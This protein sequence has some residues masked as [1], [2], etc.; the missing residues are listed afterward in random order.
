[1]L[2]KNKRQSELNDLFGY[3]EVKKVKVVEEQP[4]L[5]KEKAASMQQELAEKWGLD[6]EKISSY[7]KPGPVPKPI[8]WER[9]LRSYIEN[10][11]Q[12]QTKEPLQKPSLQHPRDWKPKLQTVQVYLQGSSTT[13]NDTSASTAEAGEEVKEEGGG[14]V[15]GGGAGGGDKEP[16]ETEAE[17]VKRTNTKYSDDTVYFY[18]QYE[19]LTG[20]A[21][22][23]T[24]KLVKKLFPKMFPKA[25]DEKR[26]RDW[27]DKGRKAELEEKGPGKGWR[28]GKTILPAPVLAFLGSLIMG[29]YL[30]GIP[31]TS[32]LIV[33]LVVGA[34]VAKRYGDK[35]TSSCSYL[36][37]A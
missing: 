10:I 3:E 17:K 14:G 25:F 16:E 7:D 23:S 22:N 19:K 12:G 6:W 13:K 5:T 20:L 30:A 1:M 37:M 8:L 9:G 15:A 4:A 34:L 18:F 24:V 35:V 29:Q 2:K 33:P 36:F 11:I 28:K 26:P 21:R 27:E 32:T 31:M